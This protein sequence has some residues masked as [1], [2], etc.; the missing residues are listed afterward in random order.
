M[1]SV[2]AY[3][4]LL[5]RH[6]A[7][8]HRTQRPLSHT[9]HNNSP[10]IIMKLYV[11]RTIECEMQR[12]CEFCE[13]EFEYQKSIHRWKVFRGVPSRQSYDVTLHVHRASYIIRYKL[14]PELPSFVSR[15]HKLS[16]E[17]GMSHQIN[18]FKCLHKVQNSCQSWKWLLLFH[19][20]RAAACMSV[21]VCV[22]AH[23]QPVSVGLC[24][25][26]ATEWCTIAANND[27]ERNSLL[28]HFKWKE[29]LFID[30]ERQLK[31]L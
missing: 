17:Y 8:W 6:Q 25:R 14:C 7:S 27:I 30:A 5:W 13:L 29:N 3:L 26:Q 18:E 28:P 24:L 15:L 10:R 1:I 22:R 11:L 19:R 16:T 21:C 9:I 12:R 23:S 4:Y 31:L 20:A 2:R